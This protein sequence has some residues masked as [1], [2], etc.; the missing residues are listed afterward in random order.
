MGGPSDGSNWDRNHPISAYNYVE[1][2]LHMSTK[3]HCQ[4]AKWVSQMPDCDR[5]TGK[6]I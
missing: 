1:A 2:I 5:S 6:K 3:Q 4:L